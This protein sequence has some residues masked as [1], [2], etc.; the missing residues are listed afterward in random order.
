MYYQCIA[1]NVVFTLSTMFQEQ[2]LE[3]LTTVS[4]YCSVTPCYCHPNV[5]WWWWW[6]WWYEILGGMC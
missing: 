2:L 3:Q 1:F 6:W 5:W 4:P